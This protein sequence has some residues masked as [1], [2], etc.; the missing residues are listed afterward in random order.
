M[1]LRNRE[2]DFTSFLN[3]LTGGTS[4]KTHLFELFMDL[5]VYEYF[6]GRKLETDTPLERLKLEVDGF[7]NAGYDYATTHGCNLSI[8]N[9]KEGALNATSIAGEN[10]KTISAN[11]GC[12]ISDW[13]SFEQYP[14][15]DASTYDYSALDT[16]ADYLPSGMR[17]CVMGPGGVLENVTSLIGY[18]NMCIMLFEDPDLLQAVFNKVGQIMVT[19]YEQSAKH[20]TVGFLISNDDWGFNTQTFFS[21]ADMR[22]Y[23]FPWHKKIVEVA[24]RHKKPI[25]LHSCG[26]MNDV[27]ADIIEE[28][29]YDAKHSY[30]DNI[31]PVEESYRRYSDKITILGGLDL[32]FLITSPVEAI[33]ERCKKLIQMSKE[34]GRY[35]LGS[36]NSLAYYVPTEKITAMIRTALDDQPANARQECIQK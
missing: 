8:N 25:V 13:E 6:A 7:Y 22:K 1:I 36:G 12:V 9:C 19:Y 33:E 10:Q 30:E 23:I 15:P 29:H 2:P 18:E 27:F 16:I 17:L 26:Y 35:M 4:S 31:L 20:D 5:P 32:D 3:V 11:E 24:H 14:W 34:K 28:M 21:V